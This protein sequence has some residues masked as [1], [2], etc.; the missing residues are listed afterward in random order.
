MKKVLIIANQFPPMAGSGIQR[1]LKFVKYLPQ[2]GYLPVVFT[3]SVGRRVLTDHSQESEIPADVKVVRAKAWEAEE[4]GGIFKYPGKIIARKFLVPDSSRLWADLSFRLAMKNVLK[5]HITLIYSTSAPYS[6]HLLAMR[7]KKQ[8]PSIKWV[9]DFRDEWSQNPYLLDKPHNKIRTAMER[10]MEEQVIKAADL[11]IANT[12]VML[13]NFVNLYPFCRDKIECIPNGYDSADFEALKGMYRRNARFTITY[14]GLLYGRRSPRTFLAAL[15]ETIKEGKIEANEVSVNFVGNYKRDMMEGVIA[16]PLLGNIVAFI[17]YMPHARCLEH[18]ARA[19]CVLLIEGS[20]RG[21]EA[22]YTGKVFEQ[23][24]IGRPIMAVIPAK[25]AA[26][27]LIRSTNTGLVADY[28][29]IEAIK[30]E[31]LTYYD[32][33]K[34]GQ[35]SYEPYHAEIAQYE[36]QTLT[37][38]LAEYFDRLLEESER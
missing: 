22:F 34:T 17:P 21:A 4:I 16:N 2:F 5:D 12:P 6:D 3:R 27:Q 23:L 33:W 19:D 9:C 37:C 25:G 38:N 13:Q 8:Y 36:R 26:A 20:G 35:I 14:A 18:E 15:E 29:D 7:L 10:N 11:I 30:V 32:Q 28:D 31:I 24:R 1:S